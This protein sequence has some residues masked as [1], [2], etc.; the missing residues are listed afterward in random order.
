MDNWF[1]FLNFLKFKSYDRINLTKKIVLFI[2]SILILLYVANSFLW[3][4]LFNSLPSILEFLT[5]IMLSLFVS[6]KVSIIW[7]PEI[8]FIAVFGAV[9][10]WFI[11]VFMPLLWENINLYRTPKCSRFELE[12]CLN[13]VDFQGRVEKDVKEF[14][15][16]SSGSGM[17]LKHYFQ[18]LLV[19]FKFKFE[20]DKK[21]KSPWKETLESTDAGDKYITKNNFLGFIFRAR[22]F[23][24]YFMLSIGT[25]HFSKTIG[26]VSQK[27]LTG[28][29]YLMITPHIRVGGAW[30]ILNEQR[31]LFS[32][33]P[34]FKV[35]GYNQTV[36]QIRDNL[37]ELWVIKPQDKIEKCVERPKD[38][39]DFVWRI[40]SY[41]LINWGQK[42]S[43]SPGDSSKI[44]FSKSIGRIG[45]RAYGK[46]RFL[47]KD[48]SFSKI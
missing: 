45:F 32:D 1:N 6:S 11:V 25:K 31:Y 47:I 15:V 4:F 41:Y 18:N 5:D 29:K 19:E 9:L 10:F 3:L 43:E 26:E 7:A 13:N 36:L 48:L 35:T 23:D 16:T 12:D 46:E 17:L 14:S 38:Q 33:I 44:P 8:L 27:S 21:N 20:V 34:N 39:P 22:D 40:P 28:E 24:N 42:S 2:A 30:D 37:L